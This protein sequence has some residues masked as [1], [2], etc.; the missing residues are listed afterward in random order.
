MQK[1]D[2]S[3]SAFF[4]AY[5]DAVTI[6]SMVLEMDF[7]LS[8]LCDDYEIIVVNDCSRDETGKILDNLAGKLKRLKVIH[9]RKNAGYGGCVR[10]GFQQASKEWVFYT[11]GDGQYDIK[12]ITLLA[13]HTDNADFITGRKI[14]RSDSYLRIIIGRLYHLVNKAVFGLKVNDVDCDFRLIRKSVLQGIKFKSDTGFFPVELVK[15]V[16]D[17]GARMV[18]VPVHHYYRKSKGS[19]FFNFRNIM[20]VARAMFEFWKEI[21]AKKNK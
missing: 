17:T 15:R 6:Q 4:P 16:Q 10:Q 3:I 9:H 7:I 12:E 21:H 20:K 8:G 5:N 11:D 18:E 14:A 2:L 1:K 13:E 19:Q